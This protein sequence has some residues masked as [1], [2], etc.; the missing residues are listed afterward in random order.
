MFKTWNV[1]D[2]LL[3]GARYVAILKQTINAGIE[4]GA[5]L[6]HINLHGSSKLINKSLD[7]ICLRA[8]ELKL[9]A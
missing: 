6:V 5:P 3:T 4:L 2:Y 1:P 9:A 7:S 8:R